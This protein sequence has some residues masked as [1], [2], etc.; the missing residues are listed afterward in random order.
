[1]ESALVRGFCPPSVEGKRHIE[2]D[3][4]HR[5]VVT[6][7]GAETR[8]DR[9]LMGRSSTAGHFHPRLLFP[10]FVRG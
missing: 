5:H 9:W 4:H 1:M 7:P 2:E 6:G 10:A 8:R 3:V